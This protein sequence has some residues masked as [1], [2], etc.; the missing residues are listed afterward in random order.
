[1]SDFNTW[2]NDHYETYTDCESEDRP[3]MV[4]D[5]QQAEIERLNARLKV[6]QDAFVPDMN[7][8]EDWIGV[9]DIDT[10]EKDAALQGGE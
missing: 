4:F 1:M 5:S 2:V 10:P 3:E 9:I 6:L 7:E 8:P